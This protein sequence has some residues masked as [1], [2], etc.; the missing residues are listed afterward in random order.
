MR[1]SNQI[2]GYSGLGLVA[3]GKRKIKDGSKYDH[4]FPQATGSSIIR[5]PNANVFETLE[6]MQEIVQKTLYQTKGIAKL[7]KGKSLEE[8]CRNIF[9][10]CYS[11]IQYKLDDAGFE[12]L[13]QPARSWRDRKTGIDCDCFS[14]FISSIL[15]NLGIPHRLR[16][17]ELHSKGYFQHVYVVVDKPSGLKSSYITID[18][19]LDTF[20]KEAEGITKIH[21]KTMGIPIQELSGLGCGC[22]SNCTACGTKAQRAPQL[23]NI[24]NA[25]QI[26]SMELK[27]LRPLYDQLLASKKQIMSN[28]NSVRALYKPEELVKT[29]DYALTNWHDKTLREKALEVLASQ[30]YKIM[31][32]YMP[33]AV[34]AMQGLL[35][36]TDR[37][38]LSLLG[39]EYRVDGLGNVTLEGFWSSIKG[40]AKSVGNFTK[41]AV[42]KAGQAIKGAAV[43]IGN[44]AVVAGKA[45]KQAAVW[46]GTK[47]KQGATFVGK[48]I[49]KYNPLSIVGRN[50]F[51]FLVRLNFRGWAS[52]LK[53]V[54]SNPS[55]EAKLKDKWTSFLISGDYPTLKRTI[56]SGASRKRLMG[57]EGNGLG[58]PVTV[59]TALAAA[60][61]IIA[62]I[63]PIIDLFKSKT[64]NVDTSAA[65]PSDPSQANYTDAE[66]AK[67]TQF[68][69]NYTPTQAVVPPTN[70]PAVIQNTNSSSSSNLLMLALAAGTLVAVVA[71]N[72]SSKKSLSGLAQ[73]KPHKVHIQ[74]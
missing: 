5:N 4:L 70:Q 65:A 56:E 50:A 8:T 58:E 23:T 35:G 66:A 38:K 6:Y 68:P 21:D 46:T 28:P 25:A 22:N 1:Y 13:R 62:A 69:A 55:G 29:I 61:G 59:G 18:P 43:K 63:T 47:V 57:L 30:D 14:I 53:K 31:S 2:Y 34:V 52:G 54:I 32:D 71:A 12:Q 24:P 39:F 20:D 45:V 3:S 74:L 44:K 10:F 73:T 7:L 49:M 42:V 36:L 60:S 26:N 64:D 17:I 33:K 51:L 19:V 11:H 40:A 67:A 37:E 15:T 27:M 72:K 41:G 16:I 9:N 48:Q